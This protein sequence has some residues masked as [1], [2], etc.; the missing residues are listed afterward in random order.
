[1]LLAFLP[2]TDLDELL[3]GWRL[4]RKT[5]YTISDQATL[6]A[7]LRG[8]LAQG[9]AENVNESEV[10]VASIAAPIRDSRGVVIAALSIAGPLQ[11]MEGATLRRYV[12]PV[13]EAAAAISRRMGYGEPAARQEGTR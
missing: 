12:R 13:T 1:M 7:Q 5:Q 6:R 9:W 11:R 4:A 3:S 8:V 2:E 10:G